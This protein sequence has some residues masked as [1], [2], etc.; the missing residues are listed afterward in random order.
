MKSKVLRLKMFTNGLKNIWVKIKDKGCFVFYLILMNSA[1]F[2]RR[3][4]LFIGLLRY[5]SQPAAIIL[6]SSPDMAYA[7]MANNINIWV[8]QLYLSCCFKSIDLR[9]L[10]VHK[11]QFNVRICFKKFDSLPPI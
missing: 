9:H 1:I 3:L 11:D 7:V 8:N 5:P 2:S 6:S 10:Y 4:F